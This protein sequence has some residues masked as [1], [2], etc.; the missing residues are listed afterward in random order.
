ML[1][2]SYLQ[3]FS[4]LQFC[5][6]SAAL[7]LELV[8]DVLQIPL[9]IRS[10]ELPGACSCADHLLSFYH[11][12][13]RNSEIRCPEQVS[14]SGPSLSSPTIVPLLVTSGEIF[15]LRRLRSCQTLTLHVQMQFFALWSLSYHALLRT[16]STG[17]CQEWDSVFLRCHS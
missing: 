7:Y 6:I 2:S 13:F 17:P 3:R 4:C 14:G 9:K 11:L 8:V 10:M 1:I 12:L 5:D 16:S 15:L